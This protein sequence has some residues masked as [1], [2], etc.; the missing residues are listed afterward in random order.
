MVFSVTMSIITRLK[1]VDVEL[2]Y[3]LPV[4]STNLP[5]GILEQVKKDGEFSYGKNLATMGFNDN[6]KKI[7]KANPFVKV[8]QIVRHFPNR[9]S[10][11]I[12]ER[13]TKYRVQ[14]E[15]NSNEYYV[16]DDEFKILDKVTYTDD[17]ETNKYYKTTTLISPQTLTI[18]AS[19]EV[20]DFVDEPELMVVFST[21][22]SGVWGEL[23]TYYYIEN[24]NLVDVNKVNF[25]IKDSGLKVEINSLER[26][27]EKVAAAIKCY[28]ENVTDNS[29]ID[30]SKSKI[31]VVD[32]P[33]GRF[34]ARVSQISK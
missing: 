14:S 18:P 11:Y 20:G 24:I 15:N 3:R 7:E 32:R 25:E 27:K 16:L 5:S 19:R 21:I 2:R 10:V 12:S 4:E 34:E 30:V 26:L 23:E 28:R 1:T 29:S 9:I 22:M 17:N 6:I 31:E 33:D 13:I 8:E